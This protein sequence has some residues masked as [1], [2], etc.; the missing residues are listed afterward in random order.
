MPR[1]FADDDR[2]L[3]TLMLAG[4]A[5]VREAGAVALAC[6]R[7]RMDI[8]NKN[9]QGGF[10]PVTDAD[11]R[12]ERV[13]RERL[14][15]VDPTLGFV[16]E[17]F[18]AEGS[19]NNYWITDP[20]DGTRAFMSGMLGWGIL[21]GLVLGGR[22]V[23]G[24]MYQPFTDE[25]FSAAGEGAFVAR[26]GERLRLAASG[27]ER[28][29]DAVLYSTDPGPLAAGG[30]LARFTELAGRCRLQRW[31]GDCYAFAMLA[32]GCIDLVVEGPLQAYDIVPLIPI[33]EAAGGVVTDL[34]GKTPLQGGAVVAAG[35]RALHAAALDVL[36]A[37]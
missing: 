28:L 7:N 23:G 29:E 14:R 5:A 20:I 25:Y 32:A 1:P 18:G 22:A 2:P 15:V 13:L 11:R 26:A 3:S 9:T 33:I 21:L 30:M 19:A 4:E 35:S 36:V 34:N 12:V 6:F 17:E 8:A 10:D 31:G 16:G 24:I 27:T 37:K